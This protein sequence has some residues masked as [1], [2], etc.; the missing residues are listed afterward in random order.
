MCWDR[1]NVTTSIFISHPLHVDAILR[2]INFGSESIDT[3]GDIKA[4]LLLGG[5]AESITLML[6][7]YAELNGLR[8]PIQ[9]GYEVFQLQD[10]AQ[11]QSLPD[12]SDPEFYLGALCV[13][14]N[15]Y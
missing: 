13:I 12:L 7:V 2:Q 8:E 4:G 14:S 3:Y 1:R 10:V 5:I 15:S 11:L 6:N 9:A